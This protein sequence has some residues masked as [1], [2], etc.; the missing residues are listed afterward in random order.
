MDQHIATRLEV[1]IDQASGLV[2]GFAP[3]LHRSEFL[4]LE[5]EK[6]FEKCWLYFGHDSELPEPGHS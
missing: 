2:P 4:E 3:G 1:G 6:I 5:H